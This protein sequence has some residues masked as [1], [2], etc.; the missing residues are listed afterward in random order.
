M[1]VTQTNQDKPTSALANNQP[2]TLSAVP[3][4]IGSPYSCSVTALETND[5]KTL[6]I[7]AMPSMSGTTLTQAARGES[8]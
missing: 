7:M 1:R 4:P 6:N 2:S 8:C 3:L 5:S